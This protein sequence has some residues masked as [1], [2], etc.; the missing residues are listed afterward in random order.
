M[1]T[2]RHLE[3]HFELGGFRPNLVQQ[4]RIALLGNSI[5][6][7]V[8]PRNGG[9]IANWA[10]NTAKS[11][12]NV[13][14]PLSYK[15][16]PFANMKYTCTKEGTTGAT[17][18]LEP[19]WPQTAGVVIADGTAEWTSSLRTD[20]PSFSFDWWHLAQA[21]SGQ[22]F[23]ETYV[24]GLSG[25]TSD[26]ILLRINAALSTNPDYVWMGGTGW[27]ENDLTSP[28]WNTVATATILTAW[29]N[30]Q[31]AV[32]AI[33]TIGKT[34]I[35]STIIPNGN[36]D[37][38]ST[39]GTYIQGNGTKA[40][41][42][43]NHK[44]REYARKYR[45]QVLFVELASLYVDT[46]V[47]NPV[48]PENT[49]TYLLQTG[50]LNK[51]TDGVH[52]YRAAQWLIANRISTMITENIQFVDHFSTGPLD[53]YNVDPNPLN[54]GTAGTKGTGVDA[55]S[56]IAN[57]MDLNCY[58]TLTGNVTSTKV[59]RTDGYPGEWQRVPYAATAGDN[60]AF[61]WHSTVSLANSGLAIGDYYEWLAEVR[62][63]ANPTL[64]PY[65]L[66][67]IDLSSG[68][69]RYNYSGQMA[70]SEQ[71]LGQ[72]ITADTTFTLKSPMA[73]V[74]PSTNTFSG[75]V[76][77]Y[78]RGA[79]SFTADFGRRVLRKATIPDIS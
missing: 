70:S 79:A 76:R 19:E 43:L 23:V 22:R 3:Q 27:F 8:F 69:P 52:P 41:Y 44:I 24:S 13:V 7:Q 77:V 25:Q 4:N 10:P 40:W 54:Y 29:N 55:G 18:D 5:L 20:S 28:A 61:S 38:S 57:L 62:I 47:A 39:F 56:S 71:D 66:C 78:A 9:S 49:A 65:L 21:L 53:T 51:K 35:L 34:P 72:F 75:Q 30:Y 64:M 68:T 59:A 12:T 17:F 67:Y 37:T 15:L 31:N 11:L 58:G 46:D 1:S 48:W 32:D 33:R 26:K 73:A 16:Y 63:A 45:D 60:A 6:Q 42:W 74:M 14:V 2:E 50:G 36:I